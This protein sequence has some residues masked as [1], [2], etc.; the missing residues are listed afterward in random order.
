MAPASIGKTINN[1]ITADGAPDYLI[2]NAGAMRRA[3]LDA[4]PHK[5]N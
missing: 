2:R 5:D 4:A 1:R 3:L